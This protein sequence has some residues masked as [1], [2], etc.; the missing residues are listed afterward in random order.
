MDVFSS[1]AQDTIT[2]VDESLQLH[3]LFYNKKETTRKVKSDQR[4]PNLLS[5]RVNKI[6]GNARARQRQHSSASQ[7]DFVTIPSEEWMQGY[8]CK[9]LSAS[10]ESVLILLKSTKRYD[11]ES[12]SALVSFRIKN[13]SFHYLDIDNNVC[14]CT[15]N[16]P[17]FPTLL[18]SNFAITIPTFDTSQEQLIDTVCF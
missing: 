15:C 12:K 18:V 11:E 7:V 10:S 1:L 2:L 5:Y 4:W 9:E 16:N 13:N 8:E 17:Y 3:F 6:S 14:L